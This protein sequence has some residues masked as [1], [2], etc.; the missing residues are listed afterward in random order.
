V[1]STANAT[2]PPSDLEA[3]RA[4]LQVYYDVEPGRLRSRP[5]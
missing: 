5:G 2:E 3:R 4:D 1:T